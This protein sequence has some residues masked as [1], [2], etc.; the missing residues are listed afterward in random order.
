MEEQGRRRKDGE[1]AGRTAPSESLREDRSAGVTTEP[2]VSTARL[3]QRP[4]L[5]EEGAEHGPSCPRE[6][7]VST[8]LPQAW[9]CPSQI[10]LK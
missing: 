4:C 5:P 7:S 3:S 10:L 8:Q 9:P 6:S 1:L 2:S